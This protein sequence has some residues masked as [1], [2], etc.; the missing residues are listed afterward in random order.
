V[1]AEAS[2]SRIESRGSVSTAIEPLDRFYRAED[3]HQK[4][5]VRASRAI[6]D[7]FRATYADDRAFV[8]STAAARV[9]GWVAGCTSATGQGRDLSR[10]GLSESTQE[11]L[12]ARMR[13]TAG[14]V[15]PG[16]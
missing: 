13:R 6:M 1:Q 5:Y 10:V 4:Y 11:E 16:E 3:Y 8:D 7:A 2:R 9:N 14:R 15:G 12:R